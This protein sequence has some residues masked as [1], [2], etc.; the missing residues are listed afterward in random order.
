M[1]KILIV[2]DS[3]TQAE[4]L[5]AI[6]EEDGHLVTKAVD[7]EKALAV[8][9]AGEFDAVISDIVMPGMSGYELC[10]R[11]KGD[12]ASAHVPVML[13]S[14]LNEPMDII[15]GLE[16]G[17]DNFLTKPCPP[18]L[19]CAR[20]RSLLSSREMRASHRAALG[21]EICFLG[22]RFTI[23]SEKEQILDLLISTF[24]DTVRANRELQ[25]NRTEL[26]EANGKLEEYA[27]TLEDKVRLRTAELVAANRELENEIVAHRAT[28]AEL[29]TASVFL[30][31]LI[32]HIPTG[33]I[34]KD[35]KTLQFVLINAEAEQM[36]GI[37][38]ERLIGLTSKDILPPEIA[39]RVM[40]RDR[41]A[42]S[43]KGVTVTPE[44]VIHTK[45]EPERYVRTRLA[46]IMGEDGEPKHLVILSENM[47]ELRK[48]E[49]QFRHAQ[50]METIGHLT[51]GIAHDF[52]NLLG[53]ILGNLDLL[54]ERVSGGDPE[55]AEITQ[56]ALQAARRGAELTQRMLA[57]ARKQPLQPRP[58]DLNDTVNGMASMLRRTIGANIDLAIVPTAD[59]WPVI[60]DPSQIEDVILNLAVNARDA[61]PNGGHL[62][63][64]T[65]SIVLDEDYASQNPE[66]VPGDYALLAVTDSGTGMSPETLDRVCEPFF[67]TKEVGRGTGLGLS[68]VY[69]FA[70]Q[71]GGHL[72]IYSELGHGTAI[73]LYLPRAVDLAE[74]PSDVEDEMAEVAGA[75]ETILLVEDN[76]GLRRT[77]AR[78]LNQLGYRVLEAEHG[79]AALDVLTSKTEIDLLLTD[80]VM[81]KGI[82][83]YELGA[84]CEQLRPGV[85][86]LFMSGYSENFLNNTNPAK[87]P[88]NLINKPCRKHELARRL[89]IMLERVA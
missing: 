78:I 5:A 53:I 56:E 72:K 32:E 9:A 23:N 20:L 14:T 46:P 70:K 45:G 52:N 15:R 49:Q 87:P 57:F 61:M 43:A 51:G 86:V 12:E 83:G 26:A 59:L 25:Y 84:T 29:R 64:E 74:R 38:S 44:E 21:V 79:L 4:M 34:V 11:L 19:L 1:A 48:L 7:A 42:V 65:S 58:F 85:K 47:S 55:N 62:L 22:Q 37:P 66:V 76:D 88:I 31:T 13:L 2:E 36:I 75:G 27:T 6:L 80:I 28:A 71:S 89:R 68:M 3:A 82:S 81:P 18:E 16:C 39:E 73:R 50:K 41:K 24:E 33:V 60:A 67:T 40:T 63:I 10:R 17:A 54:S 8:C 77:T 35:A 30:D 69:G